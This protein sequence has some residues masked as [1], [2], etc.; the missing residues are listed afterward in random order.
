VPC[1][2]IA[3]EFA[4]SPSDIQQPLQDAA[5]ALVENALPPSLPSRTSPAWEA[6]RRHK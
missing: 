6:W 4:A 3:Q 2:E 5:A 1:L